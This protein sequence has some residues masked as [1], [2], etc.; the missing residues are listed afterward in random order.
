MC[1][2]VSG[3]GRV[4]AAAAALSAVAAQRCGRGHLQKKQ[5]RRNV[6]DGAFEVLFGARARAACGE[7]THGKCVGDEC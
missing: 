6:S 7:R 2:V 5:T 1:P 4:S 3:E